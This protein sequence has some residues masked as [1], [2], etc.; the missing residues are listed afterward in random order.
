MKAA[1][2]KNQ[3]ERLAMLH[4]LLIILHAVSGVAAFFFGALI[5]PR[6]A[7]PM[8][9]AIHFLLYLVTL[10]LMVLFLIVAVAL[11]WRTLDG[12]TRALY[13]ALTALAVYTGWRGWQARRER[14]GRADGW[15]VRYVDDVGF[16]LITLFVGFVIISALDVGAPVWVGVGSGVVAILLGRRGIDWEK[17]RINGIADG[18]FAQ[19]F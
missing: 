5:L 13:A 18:S 14:E 15:R 19:R 9:T 16:T 4:T 11:D 7:R 3:D 8:P 17:T 12:A 6:R 2:G 10:W 1:I